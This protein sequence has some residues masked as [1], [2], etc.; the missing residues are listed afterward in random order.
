MIGLC[1]DTV[2]WNHTHLAVLDIIFAVPVAGLRDFD[3]GDVQHAHPEFDVAGLP[4]HADC[5]PVPSD[6]ASPA[7]HVR[8]GA[9]VGA[10]KARRTSD[11]TPL[12]RICNPHYHLV[13]GASFDSVLHDGASLRYP[14]GAQYCAYGLITHRSRS[15]IVLHPAS[16]LPVQHARVYY[17]D[18]PHAQMQAIRYP[19]VSTY[20]L[21]VS[22]GRSNVGISR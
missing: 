4:A 15:S 10:A 5:G 14:V 21:P 8:Y 1:Y 6:V 3:L 18:C 22:V 20:S 16:G 11:V 17:P 13:R 7:E 19:S 2:V 9:A 12:V